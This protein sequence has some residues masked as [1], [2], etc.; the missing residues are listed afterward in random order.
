[1]R[2]WRR[3]Q[4]IQDSDT[5]K[6]ARIVEVTVDETAANEAF[7]SAFGLAPG[8]PVLRRSR[9]FAVDDRL[10]Q[11]A[12]SYYLLDVVRSTAIVYTDTGPGGVYARLAEIG[13]EPVR[14]AERLRSRMP[15]PAEVAALELP[16]GTPII[17]ILRTA[18][19]TEDRCVEVTEMV[20]DSSAYELEYNATI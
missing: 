10:V 11:L 2:A 3:G 9:R 4:A 12:D 5:G 16:G 8:D 17:A 6:R 18:F 15:L 7:A 19:D 13:R 14:F 1:M 20:L